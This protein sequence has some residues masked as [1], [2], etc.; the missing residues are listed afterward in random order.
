VQH[1]P[2]YDKLRPRVGSLVLPREIEILFIDPNM[3]DPEYDQVVGVWRCNVP[4]MVLEVRTHSPDNGLPHVF[5]RIRVLVGEISGW[6][7]LES[8]RV[9]IW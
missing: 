3:L 9:L 2:L 5:P 8:V 6:V 4:G 1:P 7:Y